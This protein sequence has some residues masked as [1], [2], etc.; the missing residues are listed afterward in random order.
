M[1]IKGHIR[2][3]RGFVYLSLREGRRS[4]HANSLPRSVERVVGFSWIEGRA[5]SPPLETGD[6]AFVSST[7]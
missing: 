1:I 5:E 4:S 2:K 3:Y 7:T 6:S